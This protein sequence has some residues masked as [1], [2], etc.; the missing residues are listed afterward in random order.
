MTAW[1]TLLAAFGGEAVLLVVLGFFARTLIQTWIAKDLKKFEDALAREAKVFELQM[2]AN[3]DIQ[4]ERLRAAFARASRVHERQLDILQ[5]LH[6]HFLDA[7]GFLQRVSAGGRVEGELS[8]KDYNA[9]VSEAIE[10]AFNEL[11]KGRLFLPKALV[12]QCDDFFSAVFEGQ[13]DFALAHHPM[14]EPSKQAEF[15]DKSAKVAYEKVPKVMQQIE[16]A[17]RKVIADGGPS[18]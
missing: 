7:Q 1:Q 16:E 9:K 11:L 12:Q 14:I 4:I 10:S 18:E 15:W 3:A 6:R 5:N 13:R 8:P 2:K 17:A